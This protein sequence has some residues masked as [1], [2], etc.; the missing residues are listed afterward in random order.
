[1]SYNH[2]RKEKKKKTSSVVNYQFQKLLNR[3]GAR[4]TYQLQNLALKD[5]SISVDIQFAKVLENQLSKIRSY[6]STTFD[7]T[8]NQ[9]QIHPAIEIAQQFGEIASQRALEVKS[10]EINDDIFS[11]EEFD[12]WELEMKL[13]R[14]VEELYSLRLHPNEVEQ[15][16]KVEELASILIWLQENTPDISISDDDNNLNLHDK[17][18]HTRIALSTAQSKETVEKDIGVELVGQLDADAPLRSDKNIHPADEEIDSINL[19]L[20][21]KFVLLGQISSAI[22][23]AKDTGNLAI[24]L[25]LV[26]ALDENDQVD[27]ITRL[28]DK[29]KDKSAW[30]KLVYELSQNP[31]L[32]PSEKLIYTYLSGGDISE[33]LKKASSSYEEYLNV[34]VKLLLVYHSLENQKQGSF[35]YIRIPSPQAKSIGEILT[36]VSTAEGTKAKEESK[37]PIRIIA[38]SVMINKVNSLI[39]SV[40]ENTDENI[41]RILTHL[42]IC[43]ALIEPPLNAHVLSTI[44][45]FY[46]SKLSA[47]NQA[48]LIP[49]YLSF[50]PDEEEARTLYSSI[51]LSMSDKQE[52]AKQLQAAR[53]IAASVITDDTIIAADDAPKEKLENVLKMAVESVIKETESHYKQS[54]GIVAIFDEDLEDAVSE[55]DTK[56]CNA[57]EWLY[58]NRMFEDAIEATITVIRR[59]LLNG[60]LTSLRRFAEGKNFKN[61]VSDYNLQNAGIEGDD[62]SEDKKLE[63]INYENFVEGLRLLNQWRKFTAGKS[64]YDGSTVEASL[65]KTT[66]LMNNLVTNWLKDLLNSLLKE[67]RT[68][69][70]PYLIIEL[71]TIYENAREKD[72]KYLKM[73]FQLVNQVADDDANDFLEC[74]KASQRLQEFMVRVGQLS[75]IAAERG[76]EGIYCL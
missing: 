18:S 15:N 14:L 41:L 50:I 52:R 10:R 16:R 73:A 40:D 34:L 55:N 25:I 19:E 74:F 22:D 36:I 69:Y 2:N 61:L 54:D 30:T 28:G 29:G 66:K 65:D 5:E 33:N 11:Q 58:D 26:G 20:I 62:V 43:L 6:K 48:E 21:Y 75:T 7:D 53:R 27:H 57:V 38:A 56:L 35:N 44:I 76:L 4:M 51:L 70:V 71:I 13:W 17:W 68:L 67:I 42:A 72:W 46:F 24:S 8:N 37:H 63:L 32:N 3:L 47:S 59:F 64:T 23:Y 1:M 60:K 31:R 12:N 45:N 49:L 9:Q 39:Q